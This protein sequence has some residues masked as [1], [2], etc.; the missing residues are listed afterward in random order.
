MRDRGRP[1]V[2]ANRG[3]TL[4]VAAQILG[5]AN[6]ATMNTGAAGEAIRRH[7]HRVQH[8]GRALTP[9]E[10]SAEASGDLFGSRGSVLGA[11]SEVEKLP[12]TNAAAALGA[13]ADRTNFQMIVEQVPRVTDG[14]TQD[15][16]LQA[17]I[18][19]R[20]AERRQMG[21]SYRRS[22]ALLSW[23]WVVEG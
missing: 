20:R 17:H 1:T 23:A 3:M 2:R 4:E 12:G 11:G 21:S 9:L 18:G 19:H 6:S 7:V 13:G 14:R 10:S 5:H 16:E 22:H 15:K 8:G